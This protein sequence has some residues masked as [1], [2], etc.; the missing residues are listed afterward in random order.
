[1]AMLNN[2]RVPSGNLTY[3]LEMAIESSLICQLKIV[4]F[5][6]VMLV[7][8]DGNSFSQLFLAEFLWKETMGSGWILMNHRQSS[9][10]LKFFFP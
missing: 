2:Q 9:A 6:F 10:M 7:F 4:M 5:Q 3:L 1:M 8:P